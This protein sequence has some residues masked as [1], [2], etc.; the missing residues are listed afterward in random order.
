MVSLPGIMIPTAVTGSHYRVIPRLPKAV[1]IF[2]NELAFVR[3][4]YGVEEGRK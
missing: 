4:P 1:E 3:E 2:H